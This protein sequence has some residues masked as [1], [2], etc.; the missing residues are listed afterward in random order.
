MLF[1]LLM[2]V[3]AGQVAKM[4]DEALA[5]IKMIVNKMPEWSPMSTVMPGSTDAFDPKVITYEHCVKSVQIR[6][7]KNS[8]FGHI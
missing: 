4:K 2:Y 5:F 7:R 6:T 8:V 3:K 1:Y